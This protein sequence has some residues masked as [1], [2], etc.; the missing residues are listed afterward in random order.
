MNLKYCIPII[1]A[2]G[3]AAGCV[4]TNKVEPDEYQAPLFLQSSDSKIVFDK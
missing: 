3:M 1:M 4:E 2:A